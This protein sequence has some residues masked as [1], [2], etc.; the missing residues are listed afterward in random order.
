MAA[1]ELSSDLSVTT[2][3]FL[4]FSWRQLTLVGLL[5]VDFFDVFRIE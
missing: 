2:S 1:P 3:S 4:N 5:L